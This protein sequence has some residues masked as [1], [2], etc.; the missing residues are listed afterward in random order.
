ML[1]F[2]IAIIWAAS[3][4]IG[5]SQAPFY[6]SYPPGLIDGPLD[7]RLLLLI[8]TDSSAEPRF[9]I[10]EDFTS[11]QVFGKNADAWAPG[12]PQQFTGL[13]FGYPLESLAELPAGEYY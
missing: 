2:F 5:F 7:G 3:C 6:I 8:S 12:Q 1:R 4:A 13:E 9:Q 11:A 10:G